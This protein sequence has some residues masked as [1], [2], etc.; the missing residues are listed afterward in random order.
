MP[1]E[2]RGLS[3]QS[4][5]FRQAWRGLRSPRSQL[6]ARGMSSEKW[7]SCAAQDLGIGCS[8]LIYLTYDVVNFELRGTDEDYAQHRRIVKG[9]E[10]FLN[11]RVFSRERPGCS[12]TC[13]FKAIRENAR[14][15]EFLRIVRGP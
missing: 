4:R 10:H 2:F 12:R 6:A 8:R 1:P 9:Q 15:R 14:T 7:R 5:L 3:L 11:G 13:L